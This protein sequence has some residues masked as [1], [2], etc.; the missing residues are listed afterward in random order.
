[1]GT[2]FEKGARVQSEQYLFPSRIGGY[3][4]S[5]EA[6]ICADN[7]IMGYINRIT[8]GSRARTLCIEPKQHFF[9]GTR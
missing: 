7:E 6:S 8:Q 9:T 1:M 2:C 5:L 3:A 4:A